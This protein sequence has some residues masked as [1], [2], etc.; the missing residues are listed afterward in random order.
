M[1][2]LRHFIFYTSTNSLQ[3]NRLK[4]KLDIWVGKSVILSASKHIKRHLHIVYSVVRNIEHL[5][6]GKYNCTA[7]L[8]FSLFVSTCFAFEWTTII[9]VWSN[10]IQSNRRS[11]VQCFSPLW[12]V[13]S[14]WE[15]TKISKPSVRAKKVLQCRPQETFHEHLQAEVAPLWRRW[16]L[17]VA[18]KMAGCRSR[19]WAAAQAPETRGLG[20]HHPLHTSSKLRRWLQSLQPGAGLEWRH[21]RAPLW[22][23]TSRPIRVSAMV[24][25]EILIIIS[26]L[27]WPP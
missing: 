15:V 4:C 18:V 8:L 22:G 27:G 14:G 6:K 21:C 13:F 16:R 25:G 23:P 11:A 3:A 20:L 17:P 2:D 10:S 24:E 26:I 19:A 12:W 9:L 7:A 1:L 5:L